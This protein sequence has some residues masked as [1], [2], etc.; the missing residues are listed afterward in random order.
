MLAPNS[1]NV[2]HERNRPQCRNDLTIKY[3]MQFDGRMLSVIT[4]GALG[5]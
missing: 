2:D 5:G 4:I 1:I 3:L